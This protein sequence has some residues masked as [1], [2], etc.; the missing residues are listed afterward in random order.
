M[1]RRYA[2]ELGLAIICV[3]A[4]ALSGCLGPPVLE[5][6]VLGYDEITSEIEQKL[7]LINIAR[8]DKGRPPHFT[9]TSSIAATFDWT[10][11]FGVSGQLEEPSGTN[12]GNLNLGGSTSEN[13][14]FSIIPISGQDFTRRV[15][16]PFT[17]EV[18]EFVVFQGAHIDQ[19]MRLMASGIEVQKTDGS[20][21]RFI[22]ND[23]RRPSEY[24]E[25]R[26]IAMHLQWLNDH[27]KLFV[28]PLVFEETL[29]A[30]FKAVP[31]AE[32]INNGFDKGLRWRQKP[33]GNYELTRLSAGRVIVSNFDP[34]ALTDEERFELNER[35]RRN[36][37]G[38][39]YLAIRPDGVGGDFSI[40]GAIK[41]RSM[42][43]ILSFLAKGINAVKEFEVAPDSRTGKIEASPTETLKINVTDNAPGGRLPAIF[44]AGQYYS[45]NDAYWDRTSF[46]ILNILFQT[47]VGTIENVG[48]PITIS[49]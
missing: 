38:F 17:D 12:F 45:V 4:F 29:I 34:M 20:F 26:R 7:L 9:T 23:P 1:R 47:T 33:D 27:R 36:P 14:T 32:D 24:E 40:H 25:F 13:P 37:R 22:E 11:T 43:Q 10:T 44:Y 48:I 19:V 8:F 35:I 16:T 30:D 39:V 6:Q 31:R 49:K 42:F 2:K 46:A 21:V 5:R 28:R 41:L 18:F 3:S 15:V